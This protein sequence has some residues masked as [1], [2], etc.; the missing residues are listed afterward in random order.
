MTKMGIGRWV[1]VR[2]LELLDSLAL[3]RRIKL[4]Y[5]SSEA[6]SMSRG[7]IEN[8]L[9]GALCDISAASALVGFDRA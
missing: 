4:S 6:S 9:F 7:E 5:C 3:A 2:M 1:K 8:C